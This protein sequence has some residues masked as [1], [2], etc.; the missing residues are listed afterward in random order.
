MAF[1]IPGVT[2]QVLDARFAV[3]AAYGDMAAAVLAFVAIAGL[4]LRWAVAIPLVW[5]FN[6]V[7][8]LDLLN[9]VF[10]GFRHNA[11]GHLGATY[12]IPAVVVPALLVSHY[13]VF[14][15]LVRR[16]PIAVASGAGLGRRLQTSA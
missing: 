2:A 4:R 6:L 11:D 9:A 5:L 12:F 7:G 13:L 14:S 10:Q 8:T 15:L 1:L 16:Q 3:P